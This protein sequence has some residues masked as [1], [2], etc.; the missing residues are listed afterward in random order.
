MAG[1]ERFSERAPAERAALLRFSGAV[2]ARRVR[3]AV[4]VR[5]VQPG[6]AHGRAAEGT[7][8]RRAA[9]GRIARRARRA[10]G[11]AVA[12]AVGYAR[13]VLRAWRRRLRVVVARAELER[14]L[15]LGHV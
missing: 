2:R 4:E 14:K 9:M 15:A 12:A 8:P 13:M 6:D 5:Q 7:S 3:A 1:D 10:G 11:A